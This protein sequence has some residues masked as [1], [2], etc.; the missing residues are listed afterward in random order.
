[1]LETLNALKG[2]EKGMADTN[3]ATKMHSCIKVMTLTLGRK[4][5]PSNHLP[6]ARP[7]PR[8]G[9]ATNAAGKHHA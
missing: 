7:L 9:L 5:G 8:N 6:Y 4:A 3:V 1:M 2:A